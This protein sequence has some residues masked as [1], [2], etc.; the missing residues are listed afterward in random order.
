MKTQKEQR[1]YRERSNGVMEWWS[2]EPHPSTTPALRHSIPPIPPRSARAFTLIQVIGVL[3]I[4]AVLSLAL[5][6]VLIRRIDQAA[7]DRETAEMNGAVAMPSISFATTVA[8]EMA[9]ASNKVALSS[10]SVPRSFL[11][12]TNLWI[13]STNGLL[14]YIPSPKT[15][16]NCTPGCALEVPGR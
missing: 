13:G 15:A 5:A 7:R 8:N 14:P 11:I 4:I 6:P 16:S 12:D 9:V 10:R 2:V 3:A 1:N